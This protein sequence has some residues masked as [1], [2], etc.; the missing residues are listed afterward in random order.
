MVFN[1][2]RKKF[3]YGAQP[4]LTR[5]VRR[6]KGTLDFPSVAA[7]AT[8]TLTI[9]VPGATTGDDVLL[10]FVTAPTVGLV[11]QPWVSATDVVSLRVTNVTAGAVD[12]ASADYRVT[13]LKLY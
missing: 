6:A 8:S 2:N 13:V 10:S 3:S 9:S 4:L 5:D 1:F 7:G 11:F 12:A